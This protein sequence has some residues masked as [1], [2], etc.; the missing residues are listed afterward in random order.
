MVTR[1][2]RVRE[3]ADQSSARR[4]PAPRCCSSQAPCVF[5][6]AWSVADDGSVVGHGPVV[7]RP[8]PR[9]WG[10]RHLAGGPLRPP[11]PTGARATRGPLLDYLRPAHRRSARVGGARL[12]PSGH[13]LLRSASGPA[14][15][16]AGPSTAGPERRRRSAVGRRSG[17]TGWRARHAAH[18]DGAVGL[19]F[20]AAPIRTRMAH[21]WAAVSQLTST[22]SPSGASASVARSTEAADASLQAPS[23]TMRSSFATAYAWSSWS[24]R[25][26]PSSDSIIAMSTRRAEPRTTRSI[27]RHDVEL[28]V[29]DALPLV[30]HHVVRPLHRPRSQGA[31]RRDHGMEREPEIGIERHGLGIA[32]ALDRARAL[33]VAVGMRQ[34]EKLTPE[35]TALPAGHGTELREY[36][37]ALAHEGLGHPD[38]DPSSS[39]THDP[40]GSV[41]RKCRVRF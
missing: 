41:A 13:R 7:P 28:R 22:V 40:P 16:R 11:G 9:S 1:A 35:P 20:D 5:G 18:H 27:A 24:G 36:P 8:S 30:A 4:R 32:G 25:R 15:W 14:P 23:V 2:G 26:L 29:G 19:E 3:P 39:A 12:E 10:A 6:A 38:D 17:C 31:P 37:V 21:C 34:P 33:R